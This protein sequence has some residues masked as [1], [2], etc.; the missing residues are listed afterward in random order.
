MSE[1]RFIFLEIIRPCRVD[2]PQNIFI[3]QARKS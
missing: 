2:P 3:A 1:K